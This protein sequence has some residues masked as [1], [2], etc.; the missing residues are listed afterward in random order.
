MSSMRFVASA[1]TTDDEAPI[2]ALIP[3]ANT[4]DTPRDIP[5]HTLRHWAKSDRKDPKRIHLLKHHLA[6]VGACFEALIAQPTIRRRLA[7]A[8]NRDDLDDVTSARLAVF[9]ALHDIG[10]ANVGFQARIWE[11]EDLR[12]RRRPLRAGH[13]SD[14]VPV[15][16]GLDGETSPWF[17]RAL[18]WSDFQAWDGNQGETASAL[19]T[20]AMS[21]HGEPL[22]LYNSKEPN[23][24]IWRAFGS[25]DP[26]KAIRQVGNLIRGWFPLAFS[27]EGPSLPATTSF[28]H[29][30]LGL[31]TLSDWIGSDEHYFKYC[32]EPTDDYIHAARR[33]AARAVEGIGLN[34]DHQRALFPSLPGF[35]DLFEIDSD[36]HPIQE[37]TRTLPLDQ[38]LVIVES[39]TGSGKTEAAL[40]RFAHMYEAGLVDGLYFALPTRAAASQMH[41]RVTRFVSQMFPAGHRPTPVLALP[42][43]LRAGEFTGR[44]LPEYKVWWED[45]PSDRSRKLRWASE[46]AKRF[47]AAQVAVG[48][49]DQAMMAALQV[50]HSHMRAACLARNLLVVDEVH[51]SD[52]YMRVILQALLDT[53]RDAGG[54]ALLMSATLGSVARRKWLSGPSRDREDVGISLTDAISTPYPAITTWRGGEEHILPSESNGQPKEVRIDTEPVMRDFAWVAERALRAAR[55]SARVLVVRNT[56]DHAVATQQAL[57]KV[58]N[59]SDTENLFS[60][61]NVLTLHTGR[62]AA[63]DRHLLDKEVQVRLGKS[64]IPSGLVVVGTQTLEQ[65][66]DIDADFL[67]TDLCPM[68]VMLQ[69]IGRLHRHTDRSRPG[70]YRSPTCVVLTPSTG[71]LSPFLTQRANANGLGG[72]V[73][74]DLR[75]LEATRRL[76]VR[77]AEAGT[78][79]RIPEMNRKLV[80]R[81]THPDE[82]NAI[83]EE[84]GEAWLL[85]ANEVEGTGIAD[86]LTARHSVVR[87]DLSFIDRCVKFAADEE[88]I[89][90]RLGDDAVEVTFA[91]PQPSP[92]DTGTRIPGVAIPRHMLPAVVPDEPPN[93][94]P[95][96]GGFEFRVGDRRFRYDR[97]GLR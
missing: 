50:R 46:S 31:C 24:A 27:S 8:G 78:R 32:D 35:R 77:H 16:T 67:I 41:R 33:R 97:L 1:A 82:L 36:P 12:G 90:T 20:A 19:F 51:A 66:L 43:Y 75:V 68:D 7:T 93:P 30:F 10:K 96:E 56:V 13:T 64:R 59:P 58:A 17:W 62:F 40:W 65:S 23:P 94:Q 47:L 85:H 54:H 83:V 11:E 18:R 28:Q 26:E 42:G 34:I 61:R 22:D 63:E 37:S 9:A 95:D 81:T 39:E 14:L 88:R 80:E 25:L 52:P 2:P 6:D 73:Y 74:P 45:D 91:E 5:P 55:A 21:H 29:M 4:E 89:R 86:R 79:W 72:F 44:H 87:R 60:C 3:A 84:M 76:V 53:H 70:G 49:V 57:E 38:A 48:T 69:R 92:F 71:D 15:M